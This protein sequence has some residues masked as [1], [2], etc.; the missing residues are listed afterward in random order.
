MKKLISLFVFTFLITSLAIG[1]SDEGIITGEVYDQ[2]EDPVPSASVSVYDSTETNVVTGTPTDSTGAFSV[3]VDPGTYILKIT[4]LSLSPH[5]QRVEIN[6]GETEDIGSVTLTS[7]SQKMDEVVVRGESSQMEMSFDRRVFNVGRD[8]TSLGGSAV[9][10][11][12]NVPSIATD[13]E[14]NIS[15]RGNESVRILIN[16]KPSSMVGSGNVDA[17]RSIPATMIKSVEIITNPSS[18][19][20]AEGSGGIINIILTDNRELGLNGSANVGT[21]YPEEYEGSINLNYRTPNVNW[22]ADIGGDYRSEPESGNSFQR[23]SGPDT[24]YMYRERTDASESEIDGDFRFGADFYLS[25]NEILTASSYISLEEET[26]NEDIF[27][28]DLEYSQGARD[29]NVLGRINR[30]TEEEANESNFDFN[31]DYENEIDGNDDHKLVADAS[32]DI[33]RENA[34]TNIEEIT[35][36]GSGDLLEQRSK[37]TEEEMDF[38]FNAEYE[39]PLGEEGKLEAGLRSDTEW[40]DTG[41][42]AETLVD[43][44][45]ETE[46][47]YT[48]NF[49]YRENVNAAFL[50]LG[51]EFGDFSGQVGLR[52]E[53]TNIRTEI[54]ETGDVNN[55]NYIG[56]F[57]SA[58]LNY[59]FNDQQSVQLSYSRRLQR[60]WS[61]SLLPGIDFDDNRSQFTGNPSLTPEYS[62]S[63]EAGYLHYWESGSLLTSFYYRYRTDVIEDITEQ[64]DGVQFR[65]PINFANEEAWG[66]EFSADQ[67]IADR[68]TLTGNANLF[69][70]NTNGSYREGT[71]EEIIL[72]SESGNFQARMRLRWEIVDGLN[73]Q[74][75]MRYRGPSNTPQGTR[76]GMTM[77]DSGISYDILEE[78]AKITF[79]VRDVFNAQNFNNTVTTDGNPNTDFYSQREFSWS[80]RT[81]SLNFQYFFGNTESRRGGG[82]G[83]GGPG[84][85]D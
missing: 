24:T 82:G 80:T 8:I 44:T 54:K 2:Q 83:P 72:S 66:V 18:K 64:R 20:A 50:I 26:N 69:Q 36:E 29:G 61:R 52:A 49:L 6:A 71:A 79:N 17:L 70:S 31:L 78:K 40:M 56:L 77:M 76:N 13:I 55:Q 67:E 21:G 41:Y 68:L 28:T 46:P 3:D 48:Q 19:Y 74:A 4:F 34:Q 38:R 1:Q 60:P 22:F 15:L 35:Q 7:T 73:Y 51:G 42:N 30:D 37:D 84:G 59:S 10:V 53:N 39:R 27:Y 5:T 57:P 85:R 23:F 75:S 16:G 25:D 14:G 63:Y 81:F 65:F 43:G 45:W 32:F 9:N 62:N 11:L 12:D 47:A 33:S 58:F